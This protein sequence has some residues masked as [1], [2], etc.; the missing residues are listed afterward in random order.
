MAKQKS[1]FVCSQ[2]GYETPRWMGKCPSCQQWNTLQEELVQPEPAKG[3]GASPRKGT[4]S[5]RLA[6]VN[7]Q[8]W[9]RIPTG[10]GE[11]DRV[12]GGGVVPASIILCGGDPG[13]GKSTLLLQ[14]A[15]FVG[16]KRKVLY[17]SAEE[18][19]QQVKLRATRLGCKM[20]HLYILAETDLEEICHHI[21]Q[22]GPEMVVVDS[23]Q[24]VFLPALSSAPGSVSQV[25]ECASRLMRLAKEQGCAIFLVGHVTKEGALAGPKVLEHIVDTVLYFEGER[26]NIY[27]LLRAI[28][29]RFGSTNEIGIFEMRD[30][31]MTQV[32]NPSEL[33][34][35]QRHEAVSGTAVLCSM[36]GTRP[37]LAEIQALVSTSG[38]G[39]PRR[40]G[41]GTDYNRLV[42]LLAVLEKRLGY[43][44]Y[45]QD[46]YV[47][48]AGGL[49][50]DE[51]AMDLAL[52][53]AVAS[54]YRNIPVPQD[55]VLM[56][57]VGLTG[58]LRAIG[59]C[60]RRVDECEKL[61][62]SRVIL[63][64]ANKKTVKASGGVK[65]EFS[66][67]LYHALCLALGD[68]EK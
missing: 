31:G 42:M 12:L 63:P 47:N 49:H 61:G 59:H 57:E 38:F 4:V 16:Q 3:L 39:N 7:I 60:Q 50:I 45:N 55:T 53:A 9:E 44:L 8:D 27:R 23:V 17:I 48:I 18:S 43:G 35:S 13:I 14:A 21:V 19:A 66:D 34:L 11:L 62:F 2:C 65:L 5:A 24:T 58:E 41:S 22:L 20:E 51:P 54:S 33:L 68:Q 25:R 40:M 15:D 1:V 28:K 37:V 6:E 67:N 52:L 26:S 29:N 56:G 46:V 30:T 32:L 36:E 10:I 64:R